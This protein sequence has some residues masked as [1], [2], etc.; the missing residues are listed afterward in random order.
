MLVHTNPRHTHAFSCMCP[1]PYIHIQR[2]NIN[3]YIHT[4]V[5]NKIQTCTHIYVCYHFIAKSLPLGTV[6]SSFTILRYISIHTRQSQHNN[7][8]KEAVSQITEP[9]KRHHIQIWTSVRT[10]ID[11]CICTHIGV[12]CVRV[13]I[14]H[15]T[16]VSYR[17]IHT[18]MHGYCNISTEMNARS[19]RYSHTYIDIY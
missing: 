6:K 14:K 16:I 7:K 9:N 10:F 17:H 15:K 13:S 12:F 2:T 1:C 11:K 19:D 5:Y 3:I 8:T 18:F 4:Y